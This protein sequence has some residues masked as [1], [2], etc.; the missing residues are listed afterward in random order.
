LDIYNP[1]GSFLVRTPDPRLHTAG[2]M[3]YVSA[4]RIALDVW[5]NLFTLNYSTFMG[6]GGRTEPSVSQW[7]PTPPLFDLDNNAANFNLFKNGE[8]KGI[9]AIFAAHNITLSES[10]SIKTISKDG[11]W[12]ITDGA[13]Q[14]DVIASVE[15]IYV[16]DI[17]A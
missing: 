15:K 10:A 8:M 4:A 17:S 14:Y 9:R 3:Q 16:Y 2:N 5:R 13:K 7:M 6:P 1:D 11:H 12:S